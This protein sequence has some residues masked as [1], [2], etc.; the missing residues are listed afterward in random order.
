MRSPLTG[1][2]GGVAI[3]LAL[4]LMAFGVPVITA[5]LSLAS[6]LAI[7]SQVKTRIL[8]RHYC[9]VGEDEFVRYLALD[10]ARFQAWLAANPDPNDPGTIA[11]C[12]ALIPLTI[13]Q[14]PSPGS[15]PNY[16][17]QEIQSAFKEV[18][19][20]QAL[21]NILT[22]FT[23]TITLKNQ[24]TGTISLEKIIDC[25]PPLFQYS[26]NTTTGSITSSNPTIAVGA[27]DTHCGD[28]PD[29]LTWVL[30]PGINIAAQ[31]VKTLTFKAHGDTA[32][33]NL[34]QQVDH[35]LPAGVGH[36][37]HGRHPYALHRRGHR[38]ERRHKVRLQPGAI[39]A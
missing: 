8:D 23:Y 27:G 4:A 36:Q 1:A 29:Q 12:D 32:R 28:E 5:A 15:S 16:S 39:G 30:S 38:W 35:D 17:F 34:L 2:K 10:G 14:G 33:R 22:T 26:N 11:F 9:G 7:D 3:L 37:H 18:T 13:T 25:L 20:N 19:P 21:A 31:E 24:G 6:T